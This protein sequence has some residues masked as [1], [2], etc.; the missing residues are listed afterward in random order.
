MSD[1]LSIGKGTIPCE[2]IARYDSL[3]ISPKDGFFF[4]QH[5]FYSS[6]K[7]DVMTLEEYENVKKKNYQTMKRKDLGD[8][9]KIYYFQD[10]I[11]LYEILEQRPEKLCR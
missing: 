9:N 10:T 3:D 6:L 8:L 2:M 1:Y 7:D 5:S 11:I 4:L